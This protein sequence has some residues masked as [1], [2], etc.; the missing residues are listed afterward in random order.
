M[1]LFQVS[2]PG[3][4]WH[5]LTYRSDRTIPTG[6]RVDVPIGRAMR[7]GVCLGDASQSLCPETSIRTVAAVV[8][9]FSAVGGAYLHASAVIA[10]AFLVSQGA[11]LKALLPSAFWTDD[12][13]P[14]FD[15]LPVAETKPAEFFY[16]YNDGDR[17]QAYRERLLSCSGGALCIFPESEQAKAFHK[18]LVGL[19]PKDRLFFWPNRGGKSALKVW[20]AL[21]RR[22]N[23]VVVGGPGACA[24]PFNDLEL[25]IIDGESNPAWRTKCVPFFSRRSFAAARARCCG[26]RLLLGGRM[27]SSKVFLNF[28]PREDDAPDI[29][30]ES[31]R[32]LDLNGASKISFSGVQCPLPLSDLLVTETLSRVNEKKIV[33][34]LL[35]RR[36][37]AG[38]L[39]CADC[40]RSVSCQ[41]CGSSLVYEKGKTRCPA[42]GNMAPLPQRCPFCGGALL[43]G[44]FPGLEK[45]YGFAKNLLGTAPVELWH[46]DNPKTLA[47]G[48]DR[49]GRLRSGGGLLLGSRRALSL[50]D[51][52]DPALLCWLDADAEARQPHYDARF[53]TYSMALESCCRGSPA[54]RQV[55]FQTRSAGQSCL[56]SLQPGWG[57]FWKREL[58]ERR[59][60]GFPPFSS[61]AEI[62]LPP[63]FARR[64]EFLSCLGDA[65]FFVMQPDASGSKLTVLA[66]KTAVLRRALNRWFAIG[67]SRNGYPQIQVW[68]D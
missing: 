67:E 15:E 20:K 34:W 1:P 21:L 43:Q 63:G 56:A 30:R 5:S 2:V 40:G 32:I 11:I 38:E 68:T 16:R 57:F 48:R 50:L 7:R 60:L 29:R 51:V 49:L 39:R 58:A 6:A 36:G 62:E 18:S 14:P 66:P 31:L 35:D 65:G 55:M 10:R 45:L 12:A 4:W 59:S 25:V 64:E 26:A 54:E 53:N 37:I 46:A 33:F 17:R 44:M 24:A 61:L 47:E 27:P 9:D 28:S 41:R 23:S 8:D 42:C 3:P 19:I 52:L 22:K 13:L